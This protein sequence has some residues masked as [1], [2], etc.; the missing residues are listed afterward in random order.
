MAAGQ[1]ATLQPKTDKGKKQ[2]YMIIARNTETI[3]EQVA[4]ANGK[5]IPFE[6]PVFLTEKDVQTLERQKEPIQV[7]QSVSVHEL[8]QK[9]ACTVDK[10]QEMA[11]LIRE[12]PDQGGK[13]ITYVS[14]Y[15]LQRV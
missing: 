1:K 10:A 4:N 6:T 11:K 14:K 15:I 12:N 9:H 3:K 2:R 8:M 7:E 5:Q 13:K